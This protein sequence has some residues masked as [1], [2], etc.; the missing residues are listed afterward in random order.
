MM[1]VLIAVSLFAHSAAHASTVKVDTVD[2]Q[3][4]SPTS[5]YGGDVVAQDFKF[6]VNPELGRARLDIQYG[7]EFA[8][9]GGDDSYY[10][11]GESQVLVQGLSFDKTT[12]QVVY[13]SESGKVTACAKV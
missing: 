1:K 10:G 6:E 3:Y 9:G 13:K 4:S 5:R 12:S 7:I 8:T 2:A 11:P